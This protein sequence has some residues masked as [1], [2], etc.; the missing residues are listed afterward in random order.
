MEFL[1]HLNDLKVQKRIKGK[2]AFDGERGSTSSTM[3][4]KL[5]GEEHAYAMITRTKIRTLQF[6]WLYQYYIADR[7]EWP[8]FTPQ[9][10]CSGILGSYTPAI[11]PI[12]E[13][14]VLVVEALVDRLVRQNSAAQVKQNNCASTCFGQLQPALGGIDDTVL[15]QEPADIYMRHMCRAVPTV[16]GRGDAIDDVL[17]S[18]PIHEVPQQ[19]WAGRTMDDTPIVPSQSHGPPPVHE[20]AL[21]QDRRMDVVNTDSIV[22][23]PAFPL[24]EDRTVGL[25][26][27]YTGCF[28]HVM[29]LTNGDDCV[30]PTHETLQTELPA[31]N[32]MVG[33]NNGT[34]SIPTHTSTNTMAHLDSIV[35]SMD[36]GVAALVGNN[37]PHDP[38]MVRVEEWDSATDATQP[39]QPLHKSRVSPMGAIQHYG[40]VMDSRHTDGVVPGNALNEYQLRMPVSDE[41]NVPQCTVSPL[42]SHYYDSAMPWHGPP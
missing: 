38:M 11:P 37:P 1:N 14:N 35:E 36:N 24:P 31:L 19:A 9:S 27:S 20:S 6:V 40:F 13:D 15:Q 39:V 8:V 32:P 33:S 34:L 17:V 3:Y 18:E 23:T 16:A 12:D 28:D 42:P 25:I 4:I 21:L 41:R 22:P 7:V 29:N 26:N 2:P 30:A 10:T 5:I